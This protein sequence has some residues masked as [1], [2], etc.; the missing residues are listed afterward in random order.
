MRSEAQGRR[1]ETSHEAAEKEAES[2]SAKFSSEVLH[3]HSERHCVSRHHAEVW[4]T[5]GVSTP[6]QKTNGARRCRE[7]LSALEADQDGTL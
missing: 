3:P 4:T 6:A 5:T 7:L 2:D 1:K